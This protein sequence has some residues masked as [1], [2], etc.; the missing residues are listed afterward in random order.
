MG[1]LASNPYPKAFCVMTSVCVIQM[2]RKPLYAPA[3]I[4]AIRYDTDLPSGTQE[5]FF[6]PINFFFSP[7]HM[8]CAHST[9]FLIILLPRRFNH[10]HRTTTQTP[11]T[12]RRAN[13]RARRFQ[14]LPPRYHRFLLRMNR[15][16]P[17]LRI[18]RPF[19]LTEEIFGVNSRGGTTGF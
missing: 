4:L 12:R 15:Q 10:A 19:A 11:E 1:P 7:S 5:L 16:N 18:L 2:M 14:K 8:L 3:F 9:P 13:S 6:I 17:F